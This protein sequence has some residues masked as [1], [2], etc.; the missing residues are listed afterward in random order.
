LNIGLYDFMMK[1]KA[2]IVLNDAYNNDIAVAIMPVRFEDL[3]EFM[4]VVDPNKDSG[5]VSECFLAL[6]Y[7]AVELNEYIAF[8]GGKLSDYREC[9]PDGEWESYKDMIWDMEH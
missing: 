3:K 7:L 4:E 9:I 2:S 1:R 5:I 6:D 8:S